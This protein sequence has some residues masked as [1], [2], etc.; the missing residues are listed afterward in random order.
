MWDQFRSCLSLLAL[1]AVKNTPITVK[2]NF[3]PS[4]IWPKLAYYE[5]DLLFFQ[6]KITSSWQFSVKGQLFYS[7]SVEVRE[8]ASKTLSVGKI[9]KL[10]QSNPAIL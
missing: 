2:I 3:D 5:L 8:Q 6:P 10:G 7:F 9:K 1:R 4:T